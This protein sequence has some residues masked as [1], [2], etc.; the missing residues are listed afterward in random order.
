MISSVKS[1]ARVLFSGGIYG[2]VT[3]V[4]DQTLVVKVADNV[5]LEIARS[6]VSQVLD[7]S[8]KVG[9]EEGGA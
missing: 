3:N 1:G 5:K 4:K 6:A 2:T 9:A 8:A 7:A